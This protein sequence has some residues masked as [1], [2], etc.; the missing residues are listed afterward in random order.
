MSIIPYLTSFT[1]ISLVIS[2]K[3]CILCE[4]TKVVEKMSLTKKT[5]SRLRECRNKKGWTLA[6]LASQLSIT[7]SRYS[8]WEQGIRTPG[9]EQLVALAE[10]FGTTP[11]YLAGFLDHEGSHTD[12]ANYVQLNQPF[13]VKG[14]LVESEQISNS[15]CYQTAF[16]MNKG[17]EPDKLTSII[18]FDDSMA[19][20]I[21]RGDE[22][23]IDRNCQSVSHADVFAILV[24]DHIWLRWIRPE[25]DGTFT[26]MAENTDHYPSQNYSKDDLDKLAIIGRVARVSR[27]R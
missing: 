15:S 10:L 23:L 19:N 17:L 8:N 22:V 6:E 21:C 1:S 5:A 20:L 13:S 18:A 25:L 7:A 11:S 4:N 9:N 26:I 27:D 2:H 3:K 24:N 16:L 12:N 14:K